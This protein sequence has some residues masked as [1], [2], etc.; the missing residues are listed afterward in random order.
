M[1]EMMVIPGTLTETQVSVPVE[2][3][4]SGSD[5]EAEI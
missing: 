3:N 2:T 4:S 5:K 1:P